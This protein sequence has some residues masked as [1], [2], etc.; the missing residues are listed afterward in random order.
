MSNFD[1]KEFGNNI[2]KFRK[3]KGLSQENLAMLL[4]KTPATIA[5]YETG[6]II[7]NAEQIHLI[8]NELGIYEY[9]LFN[10]TKK[11]IISKKWANIW[12]IQ[13]PVFVSYEYSNLKSKAGFPLVATCRCRRIPQSE[14]VVS[15]NSPCGQHTSGSDDAA[16]EGV[17]IPPSLS[18]LGIGFC[19]TFIPPSRYRFYAVYSL[20][21][22]INRHIYRGQFAVFRRDCRYKIY[23]NYFLY[24]TKSDMFNLL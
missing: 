7:P 10:T 19:S 6:E 2:R 14:R 16:V 8:C 9:E 12:K 21:F 4:N 1:K 11:K 18:C 22:P 15:T 13:A 24:M 20:I 5:R 23:L 17:I 3:A